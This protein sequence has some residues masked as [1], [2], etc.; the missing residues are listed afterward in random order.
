MIEFKNKPVDFGPFFEMRCQ[1]CWYHHQKPEVTYEV[2]NPYKHIIVNIDEQ[3][4]GLVI[5]RIAENA[6]KNTTRGQV[7]ARY[8]Y[9][10]DT[11]VIAFQDTGCGIPEDKMQQIFERFNNTDSQGTGLGLPIC[12]EILNQMGGKITIKSEVGKGTIVWI[13]IPCKVNEIERI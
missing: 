11:L 4:L 5:D 9:T 6:A 1:N 7:R 13:A 12:Q 10:G 2:I 8:D 3:N